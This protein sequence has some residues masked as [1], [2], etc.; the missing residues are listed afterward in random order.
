MKHLGI[1]GLLM[2]LVGPA[3]LASSANATN[4]TSPEGTTYTSTIIAESGGVTLTGP[5]GFGT[6]SCKSSTIQA[7]VEFHGTANPVRARITSFT[8]GFCSGGEPTSPVFSPGKLEFSSNGSLYLADADIVVHKTLL[9][10]CIFESLSIGSSIGKFTGSN[11]TKG[12]AVFD[13]AGT[14]PS[15]QCGSATFEGTYKVVTPSTLR[16]D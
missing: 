15:N 2:A 9:G 16:V 11:V 6:V 5:F 8:L 1:L 10:T 14:I 12:N 3:T 4:L 13:I 7:T